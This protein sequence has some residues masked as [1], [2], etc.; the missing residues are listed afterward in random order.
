MSLADFIPSARRQSARATDLI[1]RFGSWWVKESRGVFPRRATDWLVGN[2]QKALIVTPEEE[3]VTIRLQ[4]SC[5]EQ[6]ALSQIAKVDYSVTS[7]DNLLTSQGCRQTDVT[8][9]ICL[10]ATQFFSR[11]IM[12]PIEATKSLDQIVLQD[13]ARKTPFR[14]DEVYHSYGST[15]LANE[16][17]LLVRQWVI[18][19]DF[20]QD[21]LTLLQLDP[22][23]VAFIEATK[24]TEDRAP[25]AVIALR[26]DSARS[27]RTRKA[28][29]IL[30]LAT[31]LMA[32]ATATT[33]YWRQQVIIDELASDLT[34]ARAKAQKVRT[35]LDNVEKK[36]TVLH[37]LRSQRAEVP[38]LLDIWEE[39]TRIFPS[40]SWLTELRLSQAQPKGEQQVVMIGFS[41][42]ASS[43]VG[44]VS[45]SPLFSDAALTAPVSMDPVEGRERFVLQVKVRKFARDTDR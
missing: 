35:Y 37:H 23:H 33:K 36:Q 31:A 10:P 25:C 44:V 15:R 21:A 32:V 12:L 42:A 4:T 43:L 28:F 22:A 8:I 20:V 11:S 24:R 2:N 19:R 41:A 7:L 18:R 17:R 45:K 9:G 27:S 16:N 30:L 40:H 5:G 26:Q 13:L 38:R 34:A 6:V 3:F 14:L 29:L 1:E 39:A